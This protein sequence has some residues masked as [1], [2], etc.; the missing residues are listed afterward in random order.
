MLS[1]RTIDLAYFQRACF[2]GIYVK[3]SQQQ[4]NQVLLVKEQF[5]V[6]I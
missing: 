3:P 5:N 6:M 1:G 4:K 2:H